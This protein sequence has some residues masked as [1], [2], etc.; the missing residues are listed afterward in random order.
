MQLSIFLTVLPDQTFP[1]LLATPPPPSE[2]V[3]LQSAEIE[4]YPTVP[5]TVFA[6]SSTKMPA[7]LRAI[8]TRGPRIR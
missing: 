6:K 3:T 1:L 2:T 5:L 4:I 7:H 8:F